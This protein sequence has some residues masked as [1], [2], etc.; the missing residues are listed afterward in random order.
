MAQLNQVHPDD[1]RD[2]VYT[3]AVGYL[4]LDSQGIPT[5]I[6]TDKWHGV[7]GTPGSLVPAD[8]VEVDEEDLRAFAT[9]HGRWKWDGSARVAYETSAEYSLQK[10]KSARR[11][12]I[13]DA[14]N[15][16]EVA[17]VMYLGKTFDADTTSIMR[18]MVV[19][20]A[21]Q[22]S[23]AAGQPFEVTW[24]C[25]DNTTTDLDAAQMI[26]LMNVIMLRGETLHNKARDLKSRI[27]EASTLEDVKSIGW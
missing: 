17:P 26:G 5:G 24:T 6:W 4:E 2:D 16:E 27:D 15:E 11:S 18:M 20:Q 25:A 8:T 19:V 9:E 21:A 13:T 7:K 10:A 12:E 14:R 23:L 3:G 22:M 1:P